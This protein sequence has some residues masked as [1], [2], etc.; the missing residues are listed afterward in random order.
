[1]SDWVTVAGIVRARGNRGEVAAENLTSG[2][3]R[4]LELKTVT[5]IDPKDRPMGEF[6]IE[7]AWEHKDMLV[8]KFAGVDNISQAEALRGCQVCIPA[9]ARPELAE[10]EFYFGDLVGCQGVDADSQIVYGRVQ[11]VQEIAGAPSLLEVEGDLLIPM[12]RSICV[13]ILPAQGVIRVRLPEGLL[14]I[15]RS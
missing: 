15:N 12:A 1:M 7:E 11:A 8:L 2:A 14:E 9:A 5:L 13:E 3:N 4:L 6:Q 10:D